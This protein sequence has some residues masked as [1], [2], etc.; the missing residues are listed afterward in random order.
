MEENNISSKPP[1]QD[2]IRRLVSAALGY[3]GAINSATIGFYIISAIF[4]TA[5]IEDLKLQGYIVFS[6][7]VTIIVILFFGSSWI[8]KNRAT[9]RVAE[10]NVVAGILL[11]SLYIYYTYLSNPTLL[12]WLSPTGIAL[13]IPPMLS[14]IIGR[15]ISTSTETKYVKQQKDA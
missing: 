10:M 4:N 3:I 8:L 7:T 13:V 11:A 14:G 2:N 12:R 9:W 1:R 6:T 5:L 15:S